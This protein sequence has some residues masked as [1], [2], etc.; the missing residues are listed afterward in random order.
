MHI[1]VEHLEFKTQRLSVE[2]AWLFSAPR[3]F[4]ND[5]LVKNKGIYLIPSDS[6]VETKIELK[7]NFFD[8]IPKMIIGNVPLQLTRSFNALEYLW[9]ALLVLSFSNSEVPAGGLVG[10]IAATANA[11]VFRSKYGIPAKV[12]L[13]V[14]ITFVAIVVL[15]LVGVVIRLL[16]GNLSS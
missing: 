4:V 10:V 15:A 2:I 12:S 1:Q 9:F 8:P 5:L 6:G 14:L 16:N 7:R 13:S 3:L 11:R